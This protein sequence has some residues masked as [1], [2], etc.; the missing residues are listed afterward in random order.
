[1]MVPSSS[2][3]RVLSIRATVRRWKD[4]APDI[5]VD[6]VPI[7]Q[8]VLCYNVSSLGCSSTKA[9]GSLRRGRMSTKKS[10]I[11]SENARKNCHNRRENRNSATEPK[12]C[13]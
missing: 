6:W 9:S 8:T 13:S 12:Q 7:A 3:V 1:M 11:M 10:L 2:P 4:F 5:K